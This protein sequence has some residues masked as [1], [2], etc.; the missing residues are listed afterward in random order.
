VVKA[1]APKPVN[2]VVGPGVPLSVLAESGVK[3]VSIGGSLYRKAMT[4]TRDCLEEL[5]A[6]KLDT[7]FKG[8]MASAEFERLVP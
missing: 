3:R 7:A 1:V 5:T 2:V 4:A 8:V 6:G